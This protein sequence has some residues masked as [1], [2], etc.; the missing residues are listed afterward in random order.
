MEYYSILLLPVENMNI[1]K[2]FAR[3][4]YSYETQK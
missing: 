3:Q 2:R 4:A 1:R